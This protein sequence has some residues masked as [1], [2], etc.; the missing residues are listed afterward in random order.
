MT[1][2]RGRVLIVR[3]RKEEKRRGGVVLSWVFPG[4]RVKQGESQAE[5]V[6]REVREE[7]GY[8]VKVEKEISSRLHPQFPVYVHYISC[9]LVDI[10]NIEMDD[11]EIEEVIWVNP[12]KLKDYFMTDFDLGVQKYLG[13]KR[14]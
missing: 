6:V 13:V 9:Q 7:T 2:E 10:E 1:D 14:S 8:T 12:H 11:E 4:G 3:R 5:A